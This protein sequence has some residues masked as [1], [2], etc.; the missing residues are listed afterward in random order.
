MEKH[1][2][3]NGSGNEEE[4]NVQNS[5]SDVRISEL[6]RRVDADLEEKLYTPIFNILDEYAREVN[7]GTDELA[8][9]PKLSSIAHIRSALTSVQRLDLFEVPASPEEPKTSSTDQPLILPDDVQPDLARHLTTLQLRNQMQETLQQGNDTFLV[10]VIMGDGNWIFRNEADENNYIP[11]QP[12]TTNPVDDKNEAS[13]DDTFLSSSSNVSS[14]SSTTQ[15]SLQSSSS[16]SS[17]QA[18]I[19]TPKSLLIP[20]QELNSPCSDITSICEQDPL[21]LALHHPLPTAPSSTSSCSSDKSTASRGTPSRSWDKAGDVSSSSSSDATQPNAKGTGRSPSPSSSSSSSSSSSEEEEDSSESSR[22]PSPEPIV[23]KA[24]PTLATTS[25]ITTSRR[26]GRSPSHSSE[27][28]FDT[29]YKRSAYVRKRSKLINQAIAGGAKI[30]EC[31]LISKEAFEKVVTVP[32]KTK[33]KTHSRTQPR[34]TSNQPVQPKGLFQCSECTQTCVTRYNLKRHVKNVHNR[35]VYKCKL[36]PG[37]YLEMRSLRE[38][39]AYHLKNPRKYICDF[40]KAVF[41]VRQRR[42]NH[43]KSCSRNPDNMP[44]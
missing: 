27:S 20:E 14:V 10:D 26:K 6:K 5:V 4:E 12:L 34:N 42:N 35:K 37:R 33:P 18:G 1:N 32:R 31:G 28:T 36:C 9:A 30:I 25:K 43:A 41:V 39:F 38:H 29:K 11:E 24:S 7:I 22:S 40:C 8:K 3:E 23:A 19:R 44:K 16:S 21:L 15:S 13:D 17:S 2:F